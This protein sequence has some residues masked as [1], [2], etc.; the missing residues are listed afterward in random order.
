M[1]HRFLFCSLLVNSSLGL[2]SQENFV[3]RLIV[4]NG[5][6]SINHEVHETFQRANRRNDLN[7]AFEQIAHE[8]YNFAQ[9]SNDTQNQDQNH[10]VSNPVIEQIDNNIEENQEITSNDSVPPLEFVEI[11]ESPK[12]LYDAD[13]KKSV[14]PHLLIFWSADEK[15]AKNQKHWD[16]SPH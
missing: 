2:A 11:D 16:F 5:Y 7:H 15:L 1:K 10:I 12:Y 3:N 4:N 9:R 13:L 14:R 6:N 8:F